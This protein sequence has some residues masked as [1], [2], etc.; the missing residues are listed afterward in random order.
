MQERHAK[1]NGRL[2]RLD[3][4]IAILRAI[5]DELPENGIFVDEV[6]QIGFAARLLYPAYKPRTYISPG[7]P[8]NT[9]PQNFSKTLTS[10]QIQDLVNFIASVTK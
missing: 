10:A 6:T 1:W 7:F 4:Q 3:Q 8:P 5:R 2:A 9:M